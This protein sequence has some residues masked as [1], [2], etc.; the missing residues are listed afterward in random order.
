M[1]KKLILA[2]L[3]LASSVVRPDSVCSV[4]S[5]P[6]N[7]IYGA[8]N[9]G[10]PTDPNDSLV[11]IEVGD[12]VVDLGGHAFTQD[13]N[14]FV[15][16][17]SGVVISPNLT[18]VTIRNGSIRSL[19]GK[20]IIVGEGC[21]DIRI[22]NIDVSTCYDGGIIINGVSIN[23]VKDIVVD[24]C[25]VSS[26]T[27]SEASTT[28]GIRVSN[29]ENITIKNCTIKG[30]DG[31]TVS[32]GF[33][34][35]L[36]AC[37]SSRIE[38]TVAH[39]NGGNALGVGVSL[40]QCQWTTVNN[41]SVFNTIARAVSSRATG[42]LINQSS[43]TTI[44][45]CAVKHTNNSLGEAYG[46]QLIDGSDNLCILCQSLNNASATIASGF[47]L[48]GT[49]TKSS[50]LKCKSRLNDG[51]VAG[52]GYGI[53]IDG[54]QNCDIWY[55]QVIA[56]SGSTGFGLTDTTSNSNNLI[57]GNLAFQN[58]TAAYDVT[59]ILPRVFPVA[60]ASVADF[61]TISSIS[62][63]INIAFAP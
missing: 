46:Y 62:K 18:N 9:T 15:G 31:G 10:N 30:N 42:L 54:P 26:C 14:N 41:C 50:L 3:M 11:C 49:E 22:E 61:T 16:G 7:Y 33:G 20:A 59:Q 37:D 63:Y 43:H 38:D 55:N 36:E 1:R 45:N 6:G 34:I 60:N 29:G 19:T 52:V 39:N 21:T 58:T 44:S 32:S 23:P 4:V 40:F 56:N 5:S 35:S 17:F 47:Y 12:V 27:G 53:L 48:N 13:P 57:V 51:G 24:N 28:Y 8:D 2:S 25:L